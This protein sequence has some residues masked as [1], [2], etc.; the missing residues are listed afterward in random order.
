MKKLFA[1]FLGIVAGAALFASPNLSAD[2]CSDN[3]F[4]GKNIKGTYSFSGFSNSLD[5]LGIPPAPSPQ[6][7]AIVGLVKFNPNGTG[8]LLT[9]DFVVIAGVLTNIHRENVPFTYT[10]G[11]IDGTQIDGTA[12]LTIP[13]FPV[14]GT[15]PV[16]SVVFKQ[17]KGKVVGFR[18]VTIGSTPSAQRWT[19]LE[20]ERF[21]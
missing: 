13:N 16:F 8:T 18:A 17:E 12:V 1:K 15:T 10:L 3:S 2:H 6:S 14:A 19:L 11:T 7:Q 4:S 21:N 9:S 5:G 20:G